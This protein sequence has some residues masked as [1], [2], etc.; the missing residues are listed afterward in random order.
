MEQ[1][2]LFP[3]ERV[4]VWGRNPTGAWL[5]VNPPNYLDR[6][7][8]EATQLLPPVES[9]SLP[10]ASSSLPRSD[11]YSPPRNIKTTRAAN[12]VSITWDPLFVTRQDE[13]GYLFEAWLCQDGIRVFSAEQT[14]GTSIT[15]VDEGGCE[16]FAG[17]QLYTAEIHGYSRPAIVFWPVHPADQ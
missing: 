4:T 1:R 14:T 2:T 15:V 9:M 8:L 13:R 16:G 12:Q 17:A 5:Y 3:G 6:C 7:W 11:L 10:Q